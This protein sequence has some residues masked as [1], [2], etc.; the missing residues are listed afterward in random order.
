MAKGAAL[1]A[2]FETG[3]QISEADLGDPQEVAS[4]A[5]GSIGM[6][7]LL[8]AGAG[9]CSASESTISALG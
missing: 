1:N 4:H 8:G 9:G 7:A 6:S 5:L 3:H 2:A